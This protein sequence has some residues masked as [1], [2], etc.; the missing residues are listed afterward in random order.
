[1]QAILFLALLMAAGVMDLIVAPRLA[2]AGEHSPVAASAAAP[3]QPQAPATAAPDPARAAA[4]ATAVAATGSGAGVAQP[5]PAASFYDLP[6]HGLMGEDAPLAAYRGQVALVVNVASKCGLTPQY[7]G[8]E[9]L[10]RELSLRGFVVLGFPSNDFREQEPGTPQEIRA[11]CDANYGV[12]F[13]LFAKQ[14]VTG[15]DK[16]PVYRF[17]TREL[18]EPS[19]NFTKYLVDRQGR[20]RQRFDPRTAPDDPKLREAI[21]RALAE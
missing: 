6:A 15:A 20:V 3:A 1:M 11:F 19:W 21:A 7:A 4:G 8:L 16:S 12:T 5:E 2:L 18:E 9:K 14:R 13:P 17:L 10:H